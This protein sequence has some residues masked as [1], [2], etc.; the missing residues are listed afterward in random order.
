MENLKKSQL[1]NIKG[2]GYT[3]W[4]IL[5]GIGLLILGIFDGYQNPNKCNN[6]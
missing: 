6:G 3:F 1:A 5:G 4:L 2:G